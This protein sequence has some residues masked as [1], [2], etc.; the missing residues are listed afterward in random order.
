VEE[1]NSRLQQA[2]E[3]NTPERPSILKQHIVLLLNPDAR[4]P[5]QNIEPIGELLKLDEFDLPRTLLLGHNCL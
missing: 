2:K 1:S 5:A 4:Q 3:I